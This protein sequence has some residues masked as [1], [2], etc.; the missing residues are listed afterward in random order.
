MLFEVV[1]I[2]FTYVY[3]FSCT[4]CV[5]LV[6]FQGPVPDLHSL[7]INAIYVRKNFTAAHNVTGY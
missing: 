3:V 6:Y 2:S 5:N 7:N 4:A 1:G